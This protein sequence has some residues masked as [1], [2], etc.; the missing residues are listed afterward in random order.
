MRKAYFTPENIDAR[1]VEM[2]REVEGYNRSDRFRFEP[3]QSALIVTDMQRYFLD[4]K[5]HA[6]IPSASAIVKSIANL[7]RLYIQNGLPVII[8]RHLN[9]EA[10]SGL[11]STWWSD[12]IREQDPLSE[13][14]PELTFPES[15]VVQ[16]SQYNGFFQ[17]VL[18][19]VLKERNVG[20]VVITGVMTHL[21]CETTAR[22]AFIRGFTVFFPI[23]GT[24][25]YDEIHHRATLLNLSHGF[26][27][28]FLMRD[29]IK[30][31]ES[32]ADGT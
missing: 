2:L 10:N 1:S 32:A 28:P 19:N 25:T 21:C 4:E 27:I 11:L 3:K 8:T 16:K 20:Q 26:V 24:A 18:E 31:L 5:S 7:A 6:Y 14:I 17:T 13:I 23:D 15:I 30:S 29:L 12:V 9:T 22:S